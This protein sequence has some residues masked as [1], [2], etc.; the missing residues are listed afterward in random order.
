[1]IRPTPVREPDHIPRELYQQ[2]HINRTPIQRIN[3]E[4]KR[5]ELKRVAVRDQLGADCLN[6]GQGGLSVEVRQ[7]LSGG[8]DGEDGGGFPEGDGV[9]APCAVLA[10]GLG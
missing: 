5:A 10:C 8:H 2:L 9:A 3:V 4:I 1:M 7:R 6:S